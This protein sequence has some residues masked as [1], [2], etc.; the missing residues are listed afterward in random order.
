MSQNSQISTF[1]D[2]KK[3]TDSTIDLIYECLDANEIPPAVGIGAL[4]TIVFQVSAAYGQN[5]RD[6]LREIL[7]SRF[8]DAFGEDL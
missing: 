3:K 6:P 8:R 2:F 4:L 1:E 7:K 5:L